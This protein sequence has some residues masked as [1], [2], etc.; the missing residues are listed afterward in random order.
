[1]QGYECDFFQNPLVVPAI[2]EAIDCAKIERYSP[3]SCFS[4][5]PLELA[6][7]ICQWICSVTEYTH[8]DIKDTRNILL[9]FGWELPEG[10]WRARL[11][12]VLFFELN[13]LSKAGFTLDWQPCLNLMNLVADGRRSVST[14]LA[15]RERVL[16]LIFALD[17]TYTNWLKNELDLNS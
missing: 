1:M 10:F 17:R 16:E 7:L 5:L 11:N 9:L 4:A 3:S 6:L 8:A 13:K 12:G 2:Q 14:G 15:N